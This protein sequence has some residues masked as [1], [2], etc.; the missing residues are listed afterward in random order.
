MFAGCCNGRSVR[1]DMQK[2]KTARLKNLRATIRRFCLGSLLIAAGLISA[3]SALA[4]CYP[5]PSGLI[6]WW[7]GDG[8]AN[9]FFGPHNGALQGGATA[10]AVGMVSQSFNFDGTNGFVSVP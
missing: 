1:G 10:N 7:P 8:T 2:F 3:S 9:D 6:A 5:A 4:Q